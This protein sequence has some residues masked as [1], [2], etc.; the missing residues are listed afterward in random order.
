MSVRMENRMEEAFAAFY[1]DKFYLLRS[2]GWVYAV[3]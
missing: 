1:G 2:G 3:E